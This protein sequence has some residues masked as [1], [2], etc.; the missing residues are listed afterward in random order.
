MGSFWART[1]VFNPSM[2][3][4][5]V[6]MNSAGVSACGGVHGKTVDVAVLLGDDGRAS[7]DRLA[8][9][10]EDTAEHILAH[11]KLKRMTE[12]ADLALGKVDALRRLEELHDRAVALPAST[13]STLQRRTLPFGS[14]ISASSS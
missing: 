2:V 12:E 13:S 9:A 7:V 4:T 3:E 14:S 5:P 10:V 1:R 6:W 8:H 11:A